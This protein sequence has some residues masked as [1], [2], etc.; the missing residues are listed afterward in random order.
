MAMRAV[1]LMTLEVLI[2]CMSAWQVHYETT[3][4]EVWEQTEGKV[5]IFV[6][7]VGTGGTITGTGR[8]LKEKKSGVKVSPTSR[9]IVL[10]H[11]DFASSHHDRLLLDNKIPVFVT[12]SCLEP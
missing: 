5:D 2:G 9:S 3:G 10:C 11:I 4:P 1:L 7:G 6:A 8:F 12:V